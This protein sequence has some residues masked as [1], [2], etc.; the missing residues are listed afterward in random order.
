MNSRSLHSSKQVTIEGTPCS[1]ILGRTSAFVS[2]M[3]RTSQLFHR[4]MLAIAVLAL[5]GVVT[6]TALAQTFSVLNNFGIGTGAGENPSNPGILAQ[7]CDGNMYGTTVNGGAN[8]VGSIF[9]ITSAGKLTVIY[10]FD[11]TH[12]YA[13]YSG[14]TLGTDC[15]FYGATSY[16]GTSGLGTIFQITSGGI[17]TP[18]YNFTGGTDGR[19]PSAPPV[20]G[21][22]GNW[23]G[24]STGDFANPGTLYQLTP[25][26]KFKLLYTFIGPQINAFSKT[27]LLLATDGNFYGT[28]EIGGTNNAGTLLK[29]AA[30]KLKI[31]FN[32]DGTHGSEPL[33]PLIQATDGNLYGTTS[34]GGSMGAG[35]VFKLPLSGKPTVLYNVPGGTGPYSPYG[36]LVQATDGNF[37]GT[38]YQGGVA[39]NGD[40]FRITSKGQ[41]TPLFDFDVTNGFRSEV[42]LLQNTNGIVYGDTYEGGAS[43]PACGNSGCGVFFSWNEGLKPF[44]SFVAPTGFGKIG[45]ARSRFSVKVLPAPPEFP[46]T[47]S[48]LPSQLCPTPI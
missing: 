47:E 46:L 7:G 28:T 12:G 25:A 10:S 48:R 31:V 39:G 32:F 29:L 41:V 34:V 26:G 36:G 24:T 18:M 4:V 1:R 44:V 30:G 11:Q 16:G 19:Y 23:Y 40:I 22:D 15:K 20:L 45:A 17:E 35:V 5:A 43:I 27:P 42:T 38:T 14:L 6:T 37:Y 33:A 8:G 9:Q 21:A 13:P 3:V 2:C